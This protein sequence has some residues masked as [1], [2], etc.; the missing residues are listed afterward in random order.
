M[1]RTVVLEKTLESPLDCKQLILETSLEENVL[2]LLYRGGP[3]L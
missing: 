3:E 1:L 2:D